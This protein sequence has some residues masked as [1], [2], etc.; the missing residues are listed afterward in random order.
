MLAALGY[1][2]CYYLLFIRLLRLVVV[3]DWWFGY[4]VGRLRL[5]RFGG[6]GH[7]D[8]SG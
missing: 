8:C 6:A 7:L 1:A 3:F 4:A 5:F 2:G